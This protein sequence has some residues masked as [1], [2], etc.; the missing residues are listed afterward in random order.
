[1][2]INLISALIVSCYNVE[3][4]SN[5]PSVNENP[6]IL[7]ADIGNSTIDFLLLNEKEYSIEK[8][9]TRSKERIFAFVQKQKML[10][11]VYVS[12]VNSVGLLNLKEALDTCFP[13]VKMHS[14]DAKTM[15]E[16]AKV[17]RIKVDNIDILGSDLF[18]DIVKNSHALGMIVIDLGTASKILYLDKDLYFRGCQIFPGLASFPEILHSKTD[19]LKNSP[20]M[21]NPPLVSLKT[22]ECISSGVINGVSSLI[23]GM[24]KAIK[25]EYRNPEAEVILTGGNAYLIKDHLK[26]W[27]EDDFVYDL[28]HTLKGLVKISG[29]DVSILERKQ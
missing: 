13:N 18:C 22:E 2:F 3:A 27:M 8:V 11:E 10:S 5:N 23:A 12:S 6:V 26:A 17:N 4:M 25:A 15:T 20:I 7:Y 19:L 14:L 16:Y 28:A 9:E 1:M 24:V 21:K 29:H